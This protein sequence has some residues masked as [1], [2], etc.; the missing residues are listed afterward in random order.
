MEPLL[1]NTMCGVLQRLS[2]LGRET[3]RIVLHAS[4]VACERPLPWRGRV[5]SCCQSCWRSLPSIQ[6]AQCRSCALPWSGEDP[7]YRCGACLSDP[8]PVDWTAAWGHYRGSLERVLHAF[9]FARHDWFSEPLACLLSDAVTQRGDLRFDA[10]TAVPMHRSK[11]RRRGYNQAELLGRALSRR[12]AI[13]FEKDLLTKVVERAPQSSLPRAERSGNVCNVFQA[14]KA[15][16]GRAI[17]LV[18]D[19]ST[20]GETLRACAKVLGKAGA[21]RVCAVVVAKTE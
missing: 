16:Q 19:V 4:C 3:A 11:L 18:D 10:L 21:E 13:P 8:L 15:V 20:T 6:S 14:S 1:R 9:K 17:L 2:L 7:D 5:G 12:I